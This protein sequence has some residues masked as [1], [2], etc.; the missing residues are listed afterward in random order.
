MKKNKDK[1][2]VFNKIEIDDATAEPRIVEISEEE[3]ASLE[4]EKAEEINKADFFEHHKDPKKAGKQ[5]VMSHLG[6]KTKEDENISKRQKVFK[7]IISIAFIAFVV[8]VL[9][10][11]F[12]T[13]FFANEQ[14]FP[15]WKEMKYI[16]KVGWIFLLAAF[17]SLFM[18]Y[19][20]KALKLSVLCKSLTGKFH[21]KTCFETGIIGHYY[22]C[23]TPLAVGGQ[24]FEIYHLSKHGVH[25]GVASSLPIATYILN[26][27]AF[28]ING[29]LALTLFVGNKLDVPNRM[30]EYFPETFR[31][32]AIIGL[33][34]CLLLPILIII[35]SLL[36]K[37]GAK[38]VHFAM[39]MGGKLRIIKKPKETEYKTVK[40]LIHNAQCLKKIF[41]RP[42]AALSCLLLS[43]V[44]QIA[45]L[46]IA[47]FSLKTFG[48]T[49]VDTPPLLEWLQI[50]QLVT[51]LNFAISF[52]PTPGNSGAADLSFYLLFASSLA[53]GMGFPAM[54][55]WRFLA[56]YSY[57]VIG[58]IFA[59]LKKRADKKK[60]M[61]PELPE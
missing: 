29:I 24:P 16:L 4:K 14:D 6:I 18:C 37:F 7:T 11:T 1:K 56:F 19:L 28:V 40:N 12:Y 26:Q 25:G 2:L 32:L 58:F 52:I 46:S 30:Y 5:V 3:L 54:A 55:L 35:F 41:T 31:V 15:T 57:I 50:A 34:L 59:T 43:F 21:F 20:A 22:N 44:E 45:A 27:F 49:T 17:F 51:I 36:P 23:V 39:F 42:I 48:Y 38:I 8:G 9:A 10:Y 13:D 60:V 47:Y 61:Y 53:A 33:T